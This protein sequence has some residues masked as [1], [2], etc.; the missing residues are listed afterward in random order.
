MRRRR[1]TG[2]ARRREKSSRLD[3]A[4]L[5]DRADRSR[6]PDEYYLWGVETVWRVP[7]EA[8]QD[9]LTRSLRRG[10]GASPVGPAILRREWS[11]LAE[12]RKRY[13]VLRGVAGA[14]VEL[15]Y[16]EAKRREILDWYRRAGWWGVIFSLVQAGAQPGAILDALMFGRWG[17]VPDLCGHRVPHLYFRVTLG[18]RPNACYLHARAVRQA[19]WYRSPKR[20][21]RGGPGR[22]SGRA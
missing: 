11:G 12:V 22:D 10:K 3:E 5:A 20:K 4:T 17:F 18:R 6:G 9:R 21:Q 14:L 8:D 2:S 19:R 13:V 16:E 15:C 7:S 1:R